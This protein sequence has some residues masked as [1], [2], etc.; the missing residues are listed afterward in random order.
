MS[1]EPVNEPADFAAAWLAH[2][3]AERARTGRIASWLVVLL[4]PAGISLDLV[5]YHDQA[6]PQF[7]P[8]RLICSALGLVLVF[9]HGSKFSRYQRFLGVPIALVPA[10]GIVIMIYM[11]QGESSPYYAGLNLVLLAVNVVVHATTWESIISVAAVLLMYL[12]ACLP[13]GETMAGQNWRMF[14][15][16]LY[17][18]VLTGVIVVTGNVYFNRLRRREFTLRFELDKNRKTLQENNQKLLELDQIKSRFFANIS[19]ELRTPLTLLLAP[20]ETL[21]RRFNRSLD[22][23]AQEMLLTMHSNGMRLLKLINDLLDLVRLESGRME[24]KHEPLEV[25]EFVK[26]LASAARQVADDKRLRL[27]THVGVDLGAVL[28]D[29]DK[30]EKILLNLVFNALKFTP[31]GGRVELRAEK[32][33]EEFVLIVADTGM[34][35]SE[36]NLPYVFDRFWQADG[37]SKRKYQGVG[38]GLAL[39]KE[40]VEIQGGKVIVE[41]QEGKGTTFT[42]RLPYQKAEPAPKPVV[43]EPA[44][45]TADSA[46]TGTTVTSEEWLANLYRRAELFP[47][48]TPVQESMRPVETS[49]NGNQPTILVADDEP[50]MLRFL[51]SQLSRHYRVLEAVDGQQAVEK[52]SQFQPDIILLDMM[53]PEKDGLQACREIRQHTPTQSIPVVLLTARA[54]EETKMAALSAGASDFLAKPFST[55]ELHVRLKNLVESHE[56]QRK[57]SKQN[58]VLE[59]TIEQLKE[60]ETQLVQTEKLASLGRM[61]AGIIH[62][63]NNPLNFATTGLFTLRN[64]GKYLAPEQQEDYKE[65]LKDV[66]DGITRVKN[67]VSDLRMFTHPETES[68]DQVEV[69]EVMTSSLRFLSN[70]WKNNVQIERKL[71]DHQTVWANKNKLIHV[72]VNLLQNSLDALKGKTFT[73]EKPTIWIEGRVENG[74]SFVVVRDNG[75][76]IGA[77]HL[78]KIFD[79]FYTTKD[80]GEGMGLGL[81]ICYRIIQECDGRI[82]V[83]TEPGKFCEFT[84]DFPVKG[85]A[86]AG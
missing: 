54:D 18:L 38:I 44:E 57:L 6:L 61:S 33:G 48:L 77:E 45:A 84:L 43:E 67:I 31:A 15:N 7:L 81:A 82:A 60:T 46:G 76:G 66:E 3:R 24:V 16:N 55:T 47:A 86:E 34:G 21:V 63:I 52:A 59:T 13:P 4:M 49:R 78:D 11:T 27:E 42:V 35:I 41:S 70:E 39:V 5:V 9:L 22:Q 25:A 71:A 8:L 10:A 50:D 20:L 51:K 40:L 72:L 28:G 56:Y 14:F 79:P 85:A 26:G 62:E 23:E 69:A 37:S 65:V 19:H 83:R 17:F 58:Q 12:L 1:K 29:R 68:R 2:E 64:K 30:L 73:D 36:K 74:R 75:T 53:M 80:V 32:Q